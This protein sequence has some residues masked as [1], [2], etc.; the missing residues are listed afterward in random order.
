MALGFLTM[1]ASFFIHFSM[2]AYI[3]FNEKELDPMTTGFLTRHQ[4]CRLSDISDEQTNAYFFMFL[5][6]YRA[7]PSS[8]FM[9]QIFRVPS[10][11]K[12]IE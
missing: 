9:Y 4:R 7:P 8:D 3:F 2:N 10:R 12:Y 1:N 5:F 6:A 11:S